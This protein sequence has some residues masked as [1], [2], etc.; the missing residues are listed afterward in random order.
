[1]T[2]PPVRHL[3][4]DADG[5]V[6][7]SVTPGGELD[8]LTAHL[9]EGTTDWL[10]RTFPADGPVLRGRADVV[11]LLAE[12]LLANGSGTDPQ[13]VYDDLW[14]AIEVSP[15]SLAV[16]R[17]LRASGVGVHLATNQDRGRAAYMKAE[18]GYDDV[19][20]SSFYSSDVGWA[21]P[22]TEFFT[23]VV[24][25]LGA[26]PDEVLFVDDSQTNVDG[27][28]AA[29]LRA[30]RWEIAD[31]MDPLRALLSSHGLTID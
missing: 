25:A 4:L 5:V 23:H 22:S 30:E 6:Q 21:K 3:L 13:R 9:G 24:G 2:R 14:L 15:E 17:T 26:R 28:S 20:D 7:Q 18:L 29:G 8:A 10:L 16:A 12:A 31:G 27:A 1:V 19:F 11:P